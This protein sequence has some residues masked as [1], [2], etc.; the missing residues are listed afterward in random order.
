M[1]SIS[2]PNPFPPDME[3]VTARNP[4]CN[5]AIPGNPLSTNWIPSISA[6]PV[7]WS[8]EPDWGGGDDRRL[9]MFYYSYLSPP[10]PKKETNII[11]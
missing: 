4:G 7:S 6:S 1:E 3:I 9:L 2:N 11:K 8:F 10:H 5:D